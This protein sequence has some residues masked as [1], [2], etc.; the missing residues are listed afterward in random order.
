MI[1]PLVV[2]GCEFV[3]LCLGPDFDIGLYAAEYE[4]K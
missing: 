2:F 1:F 3:G 4:R